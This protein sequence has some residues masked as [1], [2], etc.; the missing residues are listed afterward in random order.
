MDYDYDLLIVGGGPAGST[1]AIY[2]ARQGIK[3]LLVDKARFPRNKVCGDAIPPSSLAIL[4]ELGLLSKL[5]Q[6]PHANVNLLWQTDDHDRLELPDAQA[7]VCKRFIFDSLLFEAAKNYADTRQGWKVE[8]LL[9][10]NGQ[11][12]G[13]QGKSDSGEYAEVTA[14]V[15]VGADGCSSVV[16]R[17]V[18]LSKAVIRSGAVATRG[19]YRDLPSAHRQMEFY[20][21]QEC[22]PGYLWIFPVDNETVNVG[23]L[24]FDSTLALQK[25]SGAKL[26]QKLLD[27]DFLKERFRKAELLGRVEGWYLPMATQI[28]TVHGHG[29][30]IVGDAAGLIDPF[31]G[32]GIDTAM[33]SGKIAGLLLPDICKGKNYSA[34]VLQMYADTLQQ[35]YQSYFERR[36]ALRKMLEPPQSMMPME[37]IKTY[38]FNDAKVVP[39]EAFLQ[40]TLN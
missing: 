14:K 10:K 39:R 18:G 21:L 36:L 29:F 35:Q 34:R 31:M 4:Q 26:H 6:L 33:I 24:A 19:Y 1:T 40:A 11:V 17:K 25:L 8:N 3:V 28:R 27:S 16:A 13:I 7:L 2:A 22:N 37:V 12:F 9:F 5:N 23:V 15:I 38:L 20:Y 30:V 32:H